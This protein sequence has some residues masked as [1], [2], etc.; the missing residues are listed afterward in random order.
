MK[1]FYKDATLR[2]RENGGHEILLDGR[3]VRT[4]L[5]AALILPTAAL[6]E[7]V[8]AEWRAQ[9]EEI[10]PADMPMLTLANTSI[11]RVRQE[12]DH[13]VAT[14]AA[15]GETDMVSYLADEPPDLVAAQAAH[16]TPLRAWLAE[17]HGIEL[18][19]TAGIMPLSQEPE[20]LAAI[21]ALVAAHDDME[22]TALHE[23]T[24]LSGSVLIALALS[25]GRIDVEAAWT[26]AEV[27]EEH[28][29]K[30]WGRD[31]EAEDRRTRR[32]T[33]FRDAA[34]FLDLARGGRTPDPSV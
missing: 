29:A 28:Q 4:P 10:V 34:R 11:D 7:A 8:V 16:W 13:A 6:A 26:A 15:Y 12:R 18:L 24:T 2:V 31:E 14:I 9:G 20:T 33:A 32:R 23:F 1:R 27:D 21:R 19:A 22:L 30:F 5:R 3:P 25:R 17:T